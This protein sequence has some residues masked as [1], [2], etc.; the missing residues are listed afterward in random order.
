MSHKAIVQDGNK[1]SSKWGTKEKKRVCPYMGIITNLYIQ[2][3]KFGLTGPGY[4]H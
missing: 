3:P 2:C 4:T 1:G